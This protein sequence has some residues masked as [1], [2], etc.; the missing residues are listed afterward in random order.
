MPVAM[1]VDDD[2]VDVDVR[3]CP[4]VEPFGGFTGTPAAHMAPRGRWP[5]CGS[6]LASTSGRKRVARLMRIA[7]IV[8]V[9]H[10]RKR[11]GW[12]PDTA[13]HEDLVKRKFGSDAPDRTWFCDITQHRARDGWVY[14]AAVIDACSGGSSAGPSATG[15]P[16]RSWSTRS[17]W[18][19][20]DV[21][22]PPARSFA[23]IGELNTPH[24]SSDTDYDKP[25]SSA[26][27][28]G[29]LPASTTP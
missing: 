9:S 11:R 10:R 21:A 1:P 14:C 23:P 13:T 27:W 12:K 15:S 8:G 6:A 18:L 26:R 20:G 3:E 17:R 28:A 16:P 22:Q 7:G 19:A 4:V 25:G 5:S 24:G 29:S 2:D